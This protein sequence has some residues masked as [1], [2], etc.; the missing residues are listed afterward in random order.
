MLVERSMHEIN[1]ASST[2]Q[3]QGLRLKRTSTKHSHEEG[4]YLSKF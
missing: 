4:I 3:R 1:F 2:N